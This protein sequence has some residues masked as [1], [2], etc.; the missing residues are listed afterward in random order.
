MADNGNN[1][2]VERR[3]GKDRLMFSKF[4]FFNI[5]LLFFVRIIACKYG[6]VVGRVNI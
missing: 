2:K 1:V 6:R 5:I 3:G 4:Y